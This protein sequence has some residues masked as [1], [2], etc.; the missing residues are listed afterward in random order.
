MVESKIDYLIKIIHEQLLNVIKMYTHMLYTLNVRNTLNFPFVFY[1]FT[2]CKHIILN[3][4]IKNLTQQYILVTR[5][6]IKL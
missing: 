2:A 3:K 5:S 4:F 6:F 1:Y